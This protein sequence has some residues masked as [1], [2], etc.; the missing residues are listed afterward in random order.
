MDL[1]SSHYGCDAPAILSFCHSTLG[2]LKQSRQASASTQAN[3]RFNCEILQSNTTPVQEERAGAPQSSPGAPADTR[4]LGCAPA[5]CH[6]RRHHGRPTALTEA[7][8]SPWPPYSSSQPYRSPWQPHNLTG[9]G[10]ATQSGPQCHRAQGNGRGAASGEGWGA[11][12][13][14][15]PR[16]RWAQP[17]SQGSGTAPS[18][19]SSGTPLGLGAAVWGLGSALLVGPLHFATL[20]APAVLRLV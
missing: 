18:C 2:K 3:H 10:R 14:L 9:S 8:S 4:Q 13:R 15:S 20:G 7:H 19:R 12:E 11:R 17:H 1:L 6:G 5:V 16:G